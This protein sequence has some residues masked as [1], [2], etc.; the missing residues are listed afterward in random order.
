MS[1]CYVELYTEDDRL[2]ILLSR[3]Q[4]EPGLDVE[5]ESISSM[6]EENGVYHHDSLVL[7]LICRI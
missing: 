5:E 7:I 3:I 1:G 4:G 2:Y 6:L